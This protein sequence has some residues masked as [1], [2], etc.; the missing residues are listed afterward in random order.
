LL[1]ALAV[2]WAFLILRC[3]IAMLAG[4]IALTWPGLTSMGLV[5]LFGA[6]ALTDGALAL[7]V[8][9]SVSGMPGFGSLLLEALVRIAVGV[10]AFAAPGSA[11]LAMPTVF[12]VYA[13]ASGLVAIAVAVALGRDLT[14]E[15]PLPLAGAISI[16]FGVLLWAGPARATTMDWVFGPYAILFGLTLLALALRLRQLAAEIAASSPL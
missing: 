15:W 10:L 14:G 6:Y 9:L 11:A 4:V 3:V 1:S 5:M 2:N 13:V 12:A 7:I 16:L 8:A